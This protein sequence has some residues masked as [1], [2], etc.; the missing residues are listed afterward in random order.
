MIAIYENNSNILNFSLL[1][2][3]TN[4]WQNHSVHVRIQIIYYCVSKFACVFQS[5]EIITVILLS[6]LWAIHLVHK[7]IFSYFPHIFRELYNIF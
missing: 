2:N 1:S 5:I 4:I 3:S 6:C 7:L